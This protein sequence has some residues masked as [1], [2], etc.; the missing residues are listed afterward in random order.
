MVYGIRRISLFVGNID[1]YSGEEAACPRLTLKWFRKICIFE[2]ER[3][4]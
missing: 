1:I 2:E 3:K 4:E